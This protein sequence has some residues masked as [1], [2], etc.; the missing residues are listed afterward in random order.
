ML[1]NKVTLHPE[2]LTDLN[3]KNRFLIIYVGED[4]EEDDL[5]IDYKYYLE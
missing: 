2:T 3:P 5:F 1:N 4:A